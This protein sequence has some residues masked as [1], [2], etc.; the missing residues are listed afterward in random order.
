MIHVSV[1]TY[2]PPDGWVRRVQKVQAK[3]ENAPDNDARKAIIKKYQHLWGNLKAD[4]LKLSHGKCWFSETRDVYSYRHVDH[5][6][7]KSEVKGAD[8]SIR[9]AE[10][11]WWLAFDWTNYRISGSVGNTFKG[12]YFPLRPGSTPAIATRRVIED[13]QPLLLDPTDPYDHHLLAFDDD[14]MPRPKVGIGPWDRERVDFTIE[15]MRLDHPPLVEERQMV[16]QRCTRLIGD[17]L[18]QQAKYNGPAGGV[19][20][21]EGMRSALRELREMTR[22]ESPLSKTAVACLRKSGDETLEQLALA[23]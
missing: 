18:G 22:P 2:S 4:L 13:E 5:F 3:L 9:H 10:G 1:E 21:R 19:A 16:W 12:S 23:S 7:P 17:F 20:A 6:R 15:R 11:Y 8:G 14:G